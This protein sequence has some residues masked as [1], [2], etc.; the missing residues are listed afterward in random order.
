MERPSVVQHLATRQDFEPLE[1]GSGL[2]ASM[3]FDEPDDD[4]AAFFLEAPRTRQHRKGLADTG[5]G[6]K[7][8]GE[9]ASPA[10]FGERQQGVRIG[11]AL[12]VA[13]IVGHATSRARS[14]PRR[15]QGKVQ[16]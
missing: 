5:C 7:K 9:F 6:T 12:Q 10:L 1:Q 14:G 11:A 13:V 8:D 2:A 4:I 15:V 3:R 16:F